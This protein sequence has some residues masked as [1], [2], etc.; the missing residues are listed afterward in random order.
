MAECLR[1]QADAAPRTWFQV[2]RGVNPLS[3]GAREHY[4]RAVGELESAV[5]LAALGSE[6]TVAHSTVERQHG[7]GHEHVVVGPAGAFLMCARQHAGARAVNAGR[8]I[9]INGHRVAHVR[10]ALKGAERLSAALTERGAVGVS[11]RPVVVLVGISEFVRGRMRAPVPVLP[12]SELVRWLIRQPDV[13][14]TAEVHALVPL[15]KRLEGWRIYSAATSSHLRL[16]LRFERLRAEVTSARRHR[17]LWVVAGGMLALAVAT[18]TAMV[19][20]LIPAFTSATG[21]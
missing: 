21:G 12:L 19:A 8:M 1:A 17:R 15:V 5:A 10:D 9:L 11:V 3:A 4:T 2:M 18:A 6:W 16:T 14:S 20:L 13:Y 7:A